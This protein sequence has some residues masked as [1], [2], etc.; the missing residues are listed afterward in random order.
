MALERV[1][2]AE[3]VAA[4]LA[5]GHY[6]RRA[7]DPELVTLSPDHAVAREPTDRADGGGD[8]AALQLYNARR[9]VEAARAAFPDSA[10]QASAMALA[11]AANAVT[12]WSS[13]VVLETDADYARFGIPNVIGPDGAAPPAGTPGITALRED[14]REAVAEA[15]A[16]GNG[17]VGDID[18]DAGL[19]AAF[20][21]GDGSVPEPHEWALLAFGL[22]TLTGLWLK[23]A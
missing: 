17:V 23:R 21:T 20:A 7:V 19:E 9:A 16:L 13:L 5:G 22:L 12:P 4:S 18:P 8:P 6:P 15:E 2:G 11:R 3:S 1:V 14:D 10:A